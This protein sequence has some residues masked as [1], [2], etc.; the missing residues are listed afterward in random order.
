MPYRLPLILDGSVFEIEYGLIDVDP[1]FMAAFGEFRGVTSPVRWGKDRPAANRRQ[2]EKAYGEKPE[3]F[4][5][6]PCPP[7]G[8]SQ[9]RDSQ[10]V[11]GPGLAAPLGFFEGVREGVHKWCFLASSATSP[12]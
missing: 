5:H 12:W 2:T 7:I 1:K 8:G 10:W 6:F 4:A 9:H 3:E 11:I